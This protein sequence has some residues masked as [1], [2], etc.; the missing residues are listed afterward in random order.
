MVTVPKWLENRVGGRKPIDLT[1]VKMIAYDEA[2]EIFLQ[3][4]NHKLI[5]KVNDHFKKL[6]FKP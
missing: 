4:Y 6:N 1:H 3:E 2:D 5:N